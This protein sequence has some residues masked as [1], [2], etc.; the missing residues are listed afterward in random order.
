MS[1][2][3]II[4]SFPIR[5]TPRSRDRRRALTPRSG[6]QARAPR[7]C[8]ETGSGCSTSRSAASP[9]AA[10]AL[11]DLFSPS[12]EGAPTPAMIEAVNALLAAMSNE[13]RKAS[14]FPARIEHVAALAEHRALRRALRP[15]PRRDR[16][17]RARC[18]AGRDA[19]QHEPARLRT[20]AR[21]HEAQPLPRRHRAWARSDGRMELHLLPVRRA[22]G[23]RALGLATV[24]PSPGA[25]LLRARHADDLH[26]GVLGRR[27][28]LRRSRAVQGHPPCSRTRSAPA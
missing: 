2:T 27:A 18:G 12:P 22:V 20:L 6:R 16:R 26:A 14:C 13:Q 17:A 19:R 10:R 15:A 9:P 3:T 23:D 4:R 11:P 7:S 1:T 25:E 28:E 8:S 24:R 21:R 5:P